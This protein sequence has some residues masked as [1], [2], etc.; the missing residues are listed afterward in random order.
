MI[1]C[2][3]HTMCLRMH[4]KNFLSR[5]FYIYRPPTCQK[6][7]N[8]PKFS[9]FFRKFYFISK[10]VCLNE[11]SYLIGCL[12]FHKGTSELSYFLDL[13]WE[14]LYSASTN[15]HFLDFFFFRKCGLDFLI[16]DALRDFV[17]FVQFKK[18]DDLFECVWPFYRIGA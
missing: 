3:V 1:S 17:R 16:C 12:H 8:Y 9:G 5:A 4:L 7:L 10:E 11:K 6:I 13:F 2:I 15:L 14:Y 18:R